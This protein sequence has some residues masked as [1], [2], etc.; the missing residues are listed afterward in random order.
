[1]EDQVMKTLNLIHKND[2]KT[3]HSFSL[4]ALVL[5]LA[6][7]VLTIASYARG[8]ELQI[9]LWNQ[10]GFE[11]ELNHNKHYASGQFI[12]TD[13]REGKHRI[14]VIKRE[15]TGYNSGKVRVLYNGF[16]DIPRNRRVI[17]KVEPNR[18]V[19]II[20]TERLNSQGGHFDI[21]GNHGTSH[22]GHNDHFGHAGHHNDS[23]FGNYSSH[24]GN[25]GFGSTWSGPDYSPNYDQGSCGG[26]YYPPPMPECMS[27]QEVDRL[28]CDMEKAWFDSDKL[29]IARKRIRNRHLSSYHLS[30]ILDTFDFDSTRLEMAK[31]GFF[32]VNDKH[33]FFVVDDTFDFYCNVRELHDFVYG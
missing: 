22:G 21:F 10:S 15:Q 13:L 8:S 33:N 25:G 7:F 19:S 4:K 1:M 12:A 16:I 27:N 32:R 6:L 14:R 2:S 30:R 5:M 24:E 9:S 29:E 26:G 20:R 18:R 3:M 28:I 17:A 23:D 11:I 31:F